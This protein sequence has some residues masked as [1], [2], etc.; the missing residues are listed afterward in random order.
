MTDL[1]ISLGTNCEI[2]FNVRNT[3]QT[4]RAYPFDW[5]ITPIQA[6]PAILRDRFALDVAAHNLVH[7]GELTSIMN[8]KYGLLHHHDFGHISADVAD[9]SWKALIPTVAEK[10]RALGERFFA[11]VARAQD[12]LFVVNGDGNHRAYVAR[13]PFDETVYLEVLATLRALFP[14]TRS[15]LAIFNSVHEPFAAAYKAAAADRDILVGPVVKDY[16]DR[17]EK[18]L[19]A[20]SLC[21]WSEAL[22]AVHS[23]L[24]SAA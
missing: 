8:R 5:W 17:R 19:F 23:R 1:V 20:K 4:E 3:F 13:R 22:R 11:D 6:V 10:Y 14:H 24:Q 16:G 12:V 2:A 18:S 9:E 7:G 21:G 15:R